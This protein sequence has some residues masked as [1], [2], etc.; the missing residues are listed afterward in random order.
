MTSERKAQI[1]RWTEQGS[2]SESTGKE[3]FA[4]FEDAE[5]R[6][7]DLGRIN[8]YVLM[9]MKTIESVL[10]GGEDPVE[11]AKDR[12]RE[13]QTFQEQIRELTEQLTFARVLSNTHLARWQKAEAERDEAR[14]ELTDAVYRIQVFKRELR[15][16]YEALEKALSLPVSDGVPRDLTD[17]SLT[18]K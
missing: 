4:T 5:R 11:T 18:G 8:E 9:M 10:G 7:Q 17:A 1:R 14:Q 3:L 6:Y 16:R 12:M 2:L 15:A 13:L